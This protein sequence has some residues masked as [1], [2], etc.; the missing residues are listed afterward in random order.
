MLS[1]LRIRNQKNNNNHIIAENINKI[2]LQNFLFYN[3][4]NE[5]MN[6]LLVL[7]IIETLTVDTSHVLKI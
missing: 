5:K 7:E 6:E 1:K 4:F 3:I 2:E